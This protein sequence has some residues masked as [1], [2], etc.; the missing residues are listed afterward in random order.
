MK[1]VSRDMKKSVLKAVNA[2]KVNA[3]QTEL[4]VRSEATRVKDE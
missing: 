1:K 3:A 4:R 2:A